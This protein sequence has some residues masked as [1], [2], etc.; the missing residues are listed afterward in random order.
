MNSITPDHEKQISDGVRFLQSLFVPSDHI[1]FRPVETW[2]DGGKKKSRVDYGGVRY[3]RGGAV[4]DSG[5][6]RWISSSGPVSLES[7]LAEIN[8]RAE[9]ERTNLF[10]GVCPRFGAK[11]YDLAF[12][13][14]IVRVLWADV[15]HVTVEEALERCR[16]AGVPQPSIVVSSGHG[17]HLYWLLAEAYLIDDAGGDPV[18]AFIEFVAQGPAKKKK[19]RKYIIDQTTKERLYLDNKASVP[20]LSPKALSIQD[21]LAGLASKIGGDHTT[22]LSR[23]LRVPGTKNRKDQRNGR[24]PVPCTLIECDPSRRYPIEQFAQFVEAS[25]QK[26][27]RETVAKVKLPTARKL[28]PKGTDKFNELVL[29][30]SAAPVGTRSEADFALCCWSVEHGVN[31]EDVRAAVAG[32]GKFAE[33]PDY[34]DRT[35]G[36]AEQ[37]TRENILAKVPGRQVAEALSSNQDGPVEDDDG[38]DIGSKDDR[39]RGL[40]DAICAKHQF[41]QDAGGRLYRFEKGVYK[42]TGAELVKR[43][44]KQLCIEFAATAEWSPSLAND[45]VEFIRVDSPVLWER[46]PLDVLNVKNGL[47]RLSDR[48]LLPHSPDHLSPVQL[49]VEF[50]PSATCPAIEAFVNQ[51]F[52]ADATMLA[53]EIVAWL[54]RA[55]TAIQKAILLLGP[56]GNGKSV[57]LRLVIAFLGKVNTSGLSLHKLEADRFSASRLYGKLANICPDLPSEHLSGTSTFKAI[58]GGDTVTGE[59]KFKDSFDFT[60]YARLVFSANHAPRSQ[61]SSQGFFDRWLVI[62]FER[63]FRGTTAEIPSNVLDA[64]L[65]APRELSGLLNKALET[66]PRIDG[67]CGFTMPASVQAAAREFQSTTDPLAVWLERHTIDDPGV[68][69]V[70]KTLRI[71]FNAHLE[72]QGRPAMTEA[73]FGLAFGK[74]RPNVETKRRIVKGRQEYCYVGIGLASEQGDGTDD[75][76]GC[77]GCYGSSIY[78]THARGKLPGE[79]EGYPQEHIGANPSNP[80]KDG[81]G[82]LHEWQDSEPESDGKPRRFCRTC[83]QF[84]GF[85]QPD[86]SV[87]QP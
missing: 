35:W 87:I 79:N 84:A 30:C 50:D 26:A 54:M 40:A 41:A 39:I 24:E 21:V 37:A 86:G 7:R 69:V 25:P 19:P 71:V 49:P 11:Q 20:Q 28:S 22:D 64:Q 75:S 34:F 67:K 62:L 36:S 16:V 8:A 6:W 76:Q 1:C 77:Y 68:F 72:R 53:W 3:G 73:A 80:S 52:P 43:L 63:S 55:C 83:G 14:R 57:Y 38:D 32:I 5:Q 59:Y 17:A 46:P 51:V 2:N 33:R 42:P 58:T 12:Q 29:A 70:K 82:C 44:V 74:H 85:V 45:V 78:S 56:G 65:Q 66:L 27:H 47:L 23:L 60:P 13:I 10:F 31:R 15:D 9:R 48:A 81:N 4:D 18:P 61:D